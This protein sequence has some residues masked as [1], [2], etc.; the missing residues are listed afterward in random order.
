MTRRTPYMR[1]LSVALF[2]ATALSPNAFAS[3]LDDDFWCR[4]YGCAVVYDTQN[5]DIYDNYQFASGSCCIAYG[6]PMIGYTNVFFKLKDTG[7]Q[8]DAISS[9]ADDQ[10]F[11]FGISEDGA[12]ISNAVLSGDGYLDASD[13]LSAFSLSSTTDILLDG[14]GKQYSHSFWISS[15]NTRFS[16]RAL[17]SING[18]SGDFANTITLGDIKLT[19]NVTTN[20]NDG[21][22]QFGNRANANNVTILTGIDDLGDLSGASQRLIH[23]GRFRGLRRRNGNL[24][25]QTV[26]LDFLY[27]MPDYDMSMGVGTLDVDVSFDFYR[28]QSA[29]P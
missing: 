5:Y 18:A 12:S 19:T 29:N 24:N 10:G 15:R 6:Q 13:S 3:F 21:G 28:E 7:T 25:D 11:M 23:F 14:P 16:L 8:S 4:T 20:G 22:F 17:A 9:L 1:R 27:Q 26:R 2:A